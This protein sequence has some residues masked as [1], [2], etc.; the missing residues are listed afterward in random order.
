[1]MDNVKVKLE[2]RIPNA[3]FDIARAF[4]TKGFELYLVGGCVR[5]MA[6]GETPHDWDM[7]TNATTDEILSVCKDN[8]YVAILTG[9]AHG[10]ITIHIGDE[11]YEVTTYRID[12]DYSD[13]R[14]P[15]SVQ[16]TT[17]LHEDLA[18]RDFTI[19]AMAMDP[20]TFHVVDDF[21]G[22]EHLKN[23]KLVAVGNADA[24]LSEDALRMLRAIR[25]AIKYHMDMDVELQK[26]IHDHVSM[27][28][29]VSK[30]RITDEFRKMFATGQPVKRYFME[31][32]DLIGTIIPDMKPCFDF[33][34][35]N[36]YHIHDVYEHILY[37]V[38]YCKSNR[39]EIKMAALLHDIG[40]PDC[41][42][43]DE[44][45]FGHFYGHPPVSHDMSV[46]VL[47][48]DFRVST[49]EKERI[50]ELV[51]YHDM[52]VADT[53]KSVR[54]ALSNHGEDFMRDW[55]I[56][57]QAD[58]DDHV[59]PDGKYK[60]SV[61]DLIPIMEHILESD[62]A[63]SVKDLNID[64]NDLMKEFR[65]KPGKII[66]EI[67]NVLLDAVLEEKVDN[68]KFLLL[69]Y[70]AVYLKDKRIDPDKLLELYNTSEIDAI[71]YIIDHADDAHEK[72][73]AEKIKVIHEKMEN[74]IADEADCQYYRTV[75][76]HIF[77]KY[78]VETNRK[79]IE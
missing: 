30:E 5:D 50:L 68:E 77:S 13:G 72:D 28:S 16:F 17:S 71:R 45:G 38:D 40:K 8:H 22:V 63:F 26:A 64:G 32:R 54:R 7:C 55:L 18:R 61:E 21:N 65:L 34:Q 69:D 57:T 29:H 27:I 78:G 2:K 3:V 25:F 11:N 47:N 19:N 75:F 49:A 35:N 4:N 9:I 59:Y 41:Y 66:G 48:N 20:L 43:T 36:R 23:H 33:N 53:V 67:L 56:L 15:D 39:F 70:A 42:V 62:M 76:K 46:H 31:F 6:L 24:R 74:H 60:S 14:R 12:G 1:M 37:V 44:E 79:P 73:M 58:R 52:T 10:T 51:R